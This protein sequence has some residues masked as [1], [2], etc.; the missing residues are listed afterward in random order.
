MRAP[1]VYTCD[2]CGVQKRETNDW[3]SVSALPVAETNGSRLIVS[4]W[5]PLEVARGDVAHICGENCLLVLVGWWAQTR[6]LK[7]P[8][9]RSESARA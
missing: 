2:V 1:E 6:T 3:L 8:S 7:P 5:D 9:V 4:T